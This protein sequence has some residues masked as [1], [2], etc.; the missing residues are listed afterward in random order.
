MAVNDFLEVPD[1][2][3]VFAIGDCALFVDPESK[4]PYPPTAQLSRASGKDCCKK[5]SCINQKWR[6]IKICFQ[7]KR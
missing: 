1:F 4:R 3:G 7:I 5:P 2:P 6:K